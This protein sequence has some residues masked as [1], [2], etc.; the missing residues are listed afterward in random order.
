MI[1]GA[2]AVITTYYLGNTE[3]PV[4]AT[5][6]INEIILTSFYLKDLIALSV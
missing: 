2:G 3:H 5:N 1:L 6:N 4:A